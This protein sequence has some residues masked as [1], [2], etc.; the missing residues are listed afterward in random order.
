MLALINYVV[1]APVN[2]DQLAR[3]RIC[4]IGNRRGVAR[5]ARALSRSAI[6]R[7]SARSTHQHTTCWSLTATTTA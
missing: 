7:A 5:A 4:G 2:S 6:V 1:E 3:R